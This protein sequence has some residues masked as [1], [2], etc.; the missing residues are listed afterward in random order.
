MELLAPC[1]YGEQ[2]IT[3]ALHPNKPSKKQYLRCIDEKIPVSSTEN[4]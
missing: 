2:T 4:R 3:G 1:S